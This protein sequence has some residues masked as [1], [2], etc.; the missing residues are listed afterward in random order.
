MKHINKYLQFLGLICMVVAFASPDVADW[1]FGTGVMVAATPVAGGT[2]T[3]DTIQTDN[4]E[5]FEEDISKH[6]TK[7]EPSRY[8]FDNLLRHL[9]NDKPAIN[10]KVQFEE[11]GYFKRDGTVTAKTLI[12]GGES[13]TFTVTNIDRFNVDDIIFF[14]EVE[15]EIDGSFVPLQVKVTDKPSS[16]TLTV[17]PMGIVDSEAS[18][19][20]RVVIPDFDVTSP[21]N[22]ARITNTKT[23]TA[24]QTTPKAILPDRKWNYAQIQMA[25]LEESILAMNMRAKSGHQKYAANN[26]NAILNF[27]SE[28]EYAAKFGI[29]DS[30]ITDGDRWWTMG[31]FDKFVKKNITYPKN[32][33]VSGNWVDWTRLAFS[34]VKGSDERHLL[35]DQFLLAD[36]LKVDEVQ[37]Q[38]QGVKT[39]VKR[40]IRV[41][42]I[43]TNFGIIH[44]TFDRSLQE[45]HKNYYGLLV[46]PANV[47]RRVVEPLKTEPLELNKSGVRRVKAVRMLETYS[48]EY[49][50]PDSHAIVRGLDEAEE[51]SSSASGSA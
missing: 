49:R 19:P 10:M 23:E 44:L 32:G 30:G 36:I 24:A 21:Q 9:G 50:V 12:S 31:G 39:E 18:S 6:I 1:L 11:D 16:T 22:V 41:S 17:S 4:P 15:V 26:L 14:P 34:D 35:C 33:L 51:A 37:R 45:V 43:E 2:M 8:P 38:L 48:V 46:D 28:C 7:I 3:Y 5:Y 25:Q 20:T 29:R 47:R 13:A 40:G 27:R 42:S